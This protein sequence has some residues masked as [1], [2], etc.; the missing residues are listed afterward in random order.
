[1]DRLFFSALVLTWTCS[2]RSVR[3]S[4]CSGTA[5]SAC[6]QTEALLGAEENTKTKIYTLIQDT[7]VSLVSTTKGF[8]SQGEDDDQNELWFHGKEF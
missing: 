3:W 1:M 6:L 8:Q 2:L 7:L 4:R 5:L